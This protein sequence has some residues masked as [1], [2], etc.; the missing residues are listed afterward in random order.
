MPP[1]E[2]DSNLILSCS[3]W[4]WQLLCILYANECEPQETMTM[5]ESSK[6]QSIPFAENQFFAFHSTFLWT[7]HNQPKPRAAQRASEDAKQ[8]VKRERLDVVGGLTER[9]CL[10]EQEAVQKAQEELAKQKEVIMAKD[11][12]LKV[13]KQLQNVLHSPELVRF[14]QSCT[15]LLLL[16]PPLNGYRTRVQQRIK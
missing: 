7:I 10:A 14:S 2:V 11:K 16:C 1:V 6:A 12:E 3:Q 13:Q 8:E 4:A 15:F 9:L 5:L